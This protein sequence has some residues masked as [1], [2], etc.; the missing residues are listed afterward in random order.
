MSLSIDV[1]VPVGPYENDKRWLKECVYS[2]SIQTLLPA[3]IVFVDDQAHLDGDPTM[4][5]LVRD[6]RAANQRYKVIRNSWLLG[7]ADSW[8]IG[9]AESPSPWCFMMGADDW[10]EPSCL[11]ACADAYRR[12]SDDRGYYFVGVR[13]CKEDGTQTAETQTAPCN[14]AMVNK[15]FWKHLGGFPPAAGLGAPDGLIVSIMLGKGS[16]AG[17]LRAVANGK[18]LYNARRHSGQDTHRQMSRFAGAVIDVRDVLTREW[19]PAKWTR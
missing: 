11:A 8:N 4:L 1:I 14:A 12:T 7:C 6:L 9:I 17:N 5:G 15:G 16:E 10:L 18:P 19:E 2:L 3:C 13:Y